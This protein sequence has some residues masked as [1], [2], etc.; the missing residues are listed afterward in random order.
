MRDEIEAIAD[1]LVI[2]GIILLMIGLGAAV[3]WL[4]R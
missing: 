4:V 2:F 1:G 3:L